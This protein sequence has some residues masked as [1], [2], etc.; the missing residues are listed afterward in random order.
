MRDFSESV[1]VSVI[2]IVGLGREE[3]RGAGERRTLWMVL[4]SVECDAT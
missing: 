1:I 3:G 4:F 2:V